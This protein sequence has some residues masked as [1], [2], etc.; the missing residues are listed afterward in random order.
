MTQ[1]AEPIG[2][3]A[4]L[5]E[6]IKRRMIDGTPLDIGIAFEIGD[7]LRGLEALQSSGMELGGGG[8]VPQ[9]GGAQEALSPEASQSGGPV[10]QSRTGAPGDGA[11]LLAETVVPAPAAGLSAGQDAET[12]EGHGRRLI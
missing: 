2:T 8:P 1:E 7:A 12:V 5:L 9:S 11:G 10:S 3:V 6:E 4:S